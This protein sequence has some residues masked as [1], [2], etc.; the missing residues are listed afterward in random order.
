MPYMIDG[1]DESEDVLPDRVRFGDWRHHEM[2]Q[3]VVTN[4]D[5][6]LPAGSVRK[7]LTGFRPRDM[8]DR[9]FVTADG[10]DENGDA[11]VHCVRSCKHS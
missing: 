10:P 1:S 6:I 5:C 4:W 2:L 3:P 9:W 7:L 8:D 11:V